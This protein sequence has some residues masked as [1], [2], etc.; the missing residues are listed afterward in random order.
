M[1]VYEIWVFIIFVVGM[2]N[3]DFHVTSTIEKISEYY[4]ETNIQ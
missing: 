2:W 4:G 3:A 1:H